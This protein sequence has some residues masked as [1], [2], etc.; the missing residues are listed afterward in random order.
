MT[1]LMMRMKKLKRCFELRRTTKM[2]TRRGDR[3]RR[4]KTRKGQAGKNN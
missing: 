4:R 1:T 3:K 2:M